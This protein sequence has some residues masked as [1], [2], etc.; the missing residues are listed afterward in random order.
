MP[1]GKAPRRLHRAPLT[2]TSESPRESA[3]GRVARWAKSRPG[4]KNSASLGRRAGDSIGGNVRPQ[5]PTAAGGDQWTPAEGMLISIP[6]GL[7]CF[8]TVGLLTGAS[9]NRAASR[10]RVCVILGCRRYPFRR[11]PIL[12]FRA[13]QAAGVNLT[14]PAMQLNAV[15]SLVLA[16]VALNEPG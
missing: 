9:E 8:L 6:V 12:D 10:L 15:V 1:A 4:G 7:A 11:R 13:S 5:M 3:R 2:I 16:V 14:A